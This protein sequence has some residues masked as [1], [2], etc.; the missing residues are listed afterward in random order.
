MP[1][2]ISQLQITEESVQQPSATINVSWNVSYDDDLAAQFYA[3]QVQYK[4]GSGSNWTNGSVKLESN[5]RATTVTGLKLN[6]PCEVR[7]LPIGS[8]DYVDINDIPS[9]ITTFTSS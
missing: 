8:M 1:R 6:V 7:I 9:E 2:N 4:C 5:I 3:Y